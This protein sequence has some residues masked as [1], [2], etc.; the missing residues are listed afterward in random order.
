MKIIGLLMILASLPSCS[1]A[2][3][4]DDH[5]TMDCQVVVGSDMQRCEN[6]EVI[7]Y[8]SPEGGLACKFKG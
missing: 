2:K 5:G 7:C 3:A 6:T 4:D 8:R 1:T